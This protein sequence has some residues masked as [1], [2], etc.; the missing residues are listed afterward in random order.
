[1]NYETFSLSIISF[2]NCSYNSSFH[3]FGST[4]LAIH[5]IH[6]SFLSFLSTLLFH[7]GGG[8][9]ELMFLLLRPPFSIYNIQSFRTSVRDSPSIYCN[10]IYGWAY[11][12]SIYAKS[13]NIYFHFC[14]DTYPPPPPFFINNTQLNFFFNYKFQFPLSMCII[15]YALRSMLLLNL[16][17]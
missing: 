6:L 8:V 7:F 1:M 5:R 11:N 12:F 10:S 13:D 3:H 4:K 9:E 2:L 15:F 17:F 14:S 16:N